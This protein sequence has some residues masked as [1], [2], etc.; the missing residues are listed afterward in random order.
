MVGGWSCNVKVNVLHACGNVDDF[1]GPLSGSSVV[2]HFGSHS[3][4]AIIVVMVAGNYQKLKILAR[5]ST[6]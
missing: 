6:W 2:R 3:G 4:T 5:L 1:K